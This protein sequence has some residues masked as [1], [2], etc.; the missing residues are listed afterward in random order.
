M[1]DWGVMQAGSDGFSAVIYP[2]RQGLD[3]I[4]ETLG[5]ASSRNSTARKPSLLVT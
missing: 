2:V 5:L 1:D 3:L 4:G